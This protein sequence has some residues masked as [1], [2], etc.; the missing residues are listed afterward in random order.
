MK[1]IYALA[2]MGLLLCSRGY[3]Q[4]ISNSGFENWTQQ[5]LYENPDNYTSSN[6]WIYMSLGS[7]N[8][9]KVTDSYDGAFA[10]KLETVLAGTDT[11]Q[12]MLLIGTPGNQTINGGIPYSGIPDSISGYVKHNIQAGDTAN[13]FVLFKNNGVI[14]GMAATIFTGLQ[15]NYTRLSIPVSL[16]YAPDTIA[17]VISSSRMDPPQLPGSTLTIDS[18]S[19]LGT[20]QVFPNGSFE[21]WTSLTLEEP[22]DWATINFGS[23]Q[24]GLYSATKSTDSYAG[25]YSLKLET[26]QTIWGDTLGYVT[27]GYIG[28]NGP[29]GGMQVLTNPMKVSGYYKYFPVGA[30]TALGGAFTYINSGMI[31]SVIVKLPAQSNY[32]YFEVTLNYNAWPHID[33]LNIAFSSSNMA[34]SAYIGLG[35][36]L[37]VDNLNVVYYP[38]GINDQGN[39]QQYSVFPNPFSDAAMITFQNNRGESYDIVLYDVLGRVMMKEENIHSN[40]I[41]IHKNNL[42]AGIYQYRVSFSKTNTVV[43]DWKLVVQ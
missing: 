20:S 39:L 19:F 14:I 41:L 29:A 17:I 32:T 40:N 4:S 36:V 37:Y 9:K 10:A 24:P 30:D 21:N 12:G 43:A 33:T 5:T 25:T 2:I 11:M 18:I 23:L 13:F 16:P 38:A 27:N 28:P 3:S 22:D 15:S 26:V 7:G 35:S 6:G 34:D 31:D 1:K 42:A 8:V